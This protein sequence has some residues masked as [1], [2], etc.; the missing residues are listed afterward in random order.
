[1]IEPTI[2]IAFGAGFVSF[3]APCVLPLI[4]AYL[5][6]ITGVSLEELKFK[7]YGIYL[8]KVVFSSIFYVLGFS[9]V[10]ILLGT[11][12]GGFGSVF[13][14]YDIL[15][16]RIGGVIILVLGLEFAGLLNLPFLV[17]ERKFNLPG[18]I[19]RTGYLRSLVIGVV[20]G[21]SWSPCVGAV[22][23]AIISL[24]AIS[25]TVSRG[26]LLLFFYSLGISLPFVIV[27]LTLASAPK[28]FKFLTRYSG[29][30]SVI[31]GLFLALLGFLL[32]T[33]NYRYIHSWVMGISLPNIFGVK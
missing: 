9:L 13:R 24:A 5:G 28:Y 17:K 23:G 3:F 30:I 29:I 15:I 32:L 14:R 12:A 18:W 8:R 6:Y 16:Q 7:G 11:A 27:S 20:F 2:P 4:P 10:F 1:M 25:A 19:K 22:L 21:V 33:N 31:S 26:A